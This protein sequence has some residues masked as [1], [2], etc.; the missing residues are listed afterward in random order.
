ML[1]LSKIDEL[2]EGLSE[3]IINY[4]H[5]DDN[6]LWVGVVLNEKARKYRYE[7]FWFYG[8]EDYKIEENLKDQILQAENRMCESLKKAYAYGFDAIREILELN[9]MTRVRITDLTETHE[10]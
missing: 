10:I 2:I 7:V 4:Q 5:I 1:T 3:T 6:Y 8:A 9:P